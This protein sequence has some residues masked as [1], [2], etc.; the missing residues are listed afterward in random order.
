MS[1]LGIKLFISIMAGFIV[2]PLQIFKRIREINAIKTLER[3]VTA[4][5]A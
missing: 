4:G 3:D 5:K 2:A 1:T